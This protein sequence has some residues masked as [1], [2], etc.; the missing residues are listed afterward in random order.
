MS[1]SGATQNSQLTTHNSL[2]SKEQT[3]VPKLRF[4]E[5][6]GDWRTPSF[7]DSQ[8]KVIDGDRGS[9]YPNGAD[10]TPTGYCLFLNAKNVS[11]TGFKFEEVSFISREKDEALRKGKVQ[12]NDLI[13]T[14]RGTVGNIAIFSNEV[15]FEQLRIN[16]G[17]VVLR[18]NSAIVSPIYLYTAFG[19]NALKT[20]VKKTT[21]GSAQPQLTVKGINKFSLPLPTLPEQEK[22]AAFLSSVDSRIEQLQRKKSLLQDY[23]K[24]VMQRLFSQQLRFKDDNGNPYP[25]WEH[26]KLGEV[27]LKKS[28]NITAGSLRDIVGEY[29]VYGASGEMGSSDTFAEDQEFIG[30]V[31]DGAGVGKTMLCNP[32]TSVLGTMDIIK[33]KQGNHLRFI[34]GILNLL[35][36]NKHVN[37]STIPHIYFKDYSRENIAMPSLPEQTKIANFLSTLDTKIE[38]VTQQITQT[39]TFKKGLFQQM[40]V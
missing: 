39:Q 15:T 5:F 22:I 40:F 20:S 32:Y 6:E 36:F 9:N 7:K 2:V 30:I 10:F 29:S 17:M 4:G 37:G 12:R 35:N 27:C 16:S 3:L 26:K 21:F 19:S 38:Q 13:L 34:Y 25:D 33:E 28:S 14:T 23:K 31:K 24:G 11:K 8:V 18:T 1:N